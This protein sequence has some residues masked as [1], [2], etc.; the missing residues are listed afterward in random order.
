MIA[1]HD[2]NLVKKN[3]P[4]D[5]VAKVME[6]VPYSATAIRMVMRGKLDNN[7]ILV[8][9]ILVAKENKA[10]QDLKANVIETELVDLK[11]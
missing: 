8:A 1:K 2:L 5:W 4:R 3:L 9:I 6:K 11:A 7:E 10:L